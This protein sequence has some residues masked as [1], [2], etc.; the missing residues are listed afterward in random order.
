LEVL[1]IDGNS[2]E[3]HI[4]EIGLEDATFNFLAKVA[5][6]L[7]LCVDLLIAIQQTRK[8]RGVKLTFAQ[9][10]NSPPFLYKKFITVS[11]KTSHWTQ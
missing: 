10:I 4:E 6:A 11:T 3:M 2:F 9:V 5:V 1:S 7:V 8:H